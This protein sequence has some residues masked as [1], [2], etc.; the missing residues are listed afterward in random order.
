MLLGRGI[1]WHAVLK[2]TRE[3]KVKGTESVIS[4]YKK[5]RTH[6]S[7]LNKPLCAMLIMSAPIN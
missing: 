7:R 6:T 2:S 5:G 3:T 1:I 4:W